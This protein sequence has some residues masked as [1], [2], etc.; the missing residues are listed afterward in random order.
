MVGLRKYKLGI[1][2][3]GVMMLSPGVHRISQMLMMML[4]LGC[5]G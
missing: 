4:S 1:G 3:L 5:T 2:Q